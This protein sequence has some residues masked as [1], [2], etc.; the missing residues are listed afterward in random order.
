MKENIVLFL[1]YFI[2]FIASYIAYR[3]SHLV[4]S[5]KLILYICVYFVLIQLYFEFINYTIISLRDKGVYLEFEHAYISVLNLLIAANLTGV[6]FVVLIYTR[7][8]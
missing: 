8:K 7:K 2:F 5:K 4:K 6:L 1:I 3:F